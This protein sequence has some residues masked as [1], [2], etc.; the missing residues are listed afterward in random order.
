MR[1][2]GADFEL[3]AGLL[4][5]EGVVR[6]RTEIDRLEYCVDDDLDP[7]Q[8]YNIVTAHLRPAPGSRSFHARPG[9]VLEQ[10]LRRLRQ[11]VARSDRT[12]HLRTAAPADFTVDAATVILELPDQLR[13]RQ[14]VFAQTGGLHAAALVRPN[15]RPDRGARGCRPAQ[16]GRQADRLGV[17]RRAHAA[18]RIRSCWSAGG[19]ASRSHRNAPP[20]ESRAGG[21]LRA[22][23]LCA[24][25]L[26]NRFGMTLDRL[27]AGRAFQHLRPSA[28]DHDGSRA[29]V[30]NG[31]AHRFSRHPD[32]GRGCVRQ[33][34]SGHG[35]G[36]AH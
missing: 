33:P 15:G 18:C 13:E 36:C 22:K 14:S 27:S 16:R 12:A 17:A 25:D 28:P 5:A 11:S 19:S 3:A 30:L 23:Q 8:R 32:E 2:P 6:D 7:T 21:R 1:T 10:R 26:A 35:D 31:R 34:P 24:V 20:P 9:D 4:H 29:F